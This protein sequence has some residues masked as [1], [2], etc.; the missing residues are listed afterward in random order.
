MALTKTAPHSDADDQ[1]SG[2]VRWRAVILGL[3]LT[4]LICAY[5]PFHNCFRHGTPLGGGHFPLAPFFILTWLV[6][7][8]AGIRCLF[9]ARTP[10]TGRE[11]LCA[12][13]LM[14][15]GSGIA[16]TGLARTFFINLT[17]PYH[18]ATIGNNWAAVLQP[19]LPDGWYPADRQ[20]ITDLYNGLPGGRELGLGALMAKIPWQA[21]VRPLL[22]WAVFIF[23]CYG[24]MIGLTNL[25]SRQWLRNERMNLPLLRVPEM[26]ETAFDQQQLWP[27]FKDRFLLAG[28]S[29][30]V[31]LHLLNGLH[32]YFPQV[33]QVPTLILAGPLFPQ[34][35]LF[36]GFY[37]LKIYIYPA[38]IGFAF[39]TTKQISASFFIFYLLGCLLTG[40]L[41]LLGFAIPAAA[42]GTTFGPTLSHPEEMQMIGAGGI[43]F[44]FIVWLGRR[45][46]VDIVA[47]VAG[48]QAAPT[49]ETEW[50]SLS[51]AFWISLGCS[52]GLVAWCLYFGF[53]LLPALFLLGAGFMLL[54]V[55][56]RVICQGGI[57]YFTLTAAPMD[58]IFA[59]FGSRFFTATGVLMAAVIQKVLFVDFRETLMP[60]LM[61]GAKITQAT[62]Q[63]RT[64]LT[65]IGLVLVLSVGVS[66]VA[67][68]VLCYRY[69]L[70]ELNLDW[71]TR[72][73]VGVYENVQTLIEQ[74]MTPNRFVLSFAIVGAVFMLALVVAYHRFYWWPLHPIGYLTAY[75]SAAR[76]LWFSFFIGWACNTLC[77]RYGGV[78]LFKRARLFFIGLILGDFMMGGLWALVG[79]FMDTS[80]LVLPD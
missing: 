67:M 42:L 62:R 3:L 1:T 8:T 61:H 29:I 2:R 58:G 37:K 79:I 54:I 6:I 10:L 30:P 25:M 55:A 48:R 14:V 44:L 20:A 23:L 64:M 72:T 80:Y 71:A 34:T 60:S 27:F 7:L 32:F 45:H 77:M 46:I 11:L 75:S 53:P 65:G 52:I 74:P 40:L 43:F 13:V 73:T 4:V 50:I 68:L 36:A 9:N 66:F 78:G 31:L 57:A 38:F 59:L 51:G 35:G 39:L 33:P 47:Q 70:R 24:V 16:Y 15:I 26:L 22:G 76:I 5:T 12:W 56:T 41:G 69:G 17:A 28:L 63:K 49:L 19:L 21:W 18:F